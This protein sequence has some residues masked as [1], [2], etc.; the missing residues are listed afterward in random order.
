M[1][2]VDYNSEVGD[3]LALLID[4]LSPFVEGV[5]ATKLP[6]EVSWASLLE[7]KDSIAGR[8]GGIYSPRDLSLLLRALTERIGELGFPFDRELPR[9]GQTY[10][11]ELR[12][13]RNQ[14]AHNQ[15]F[16]PQTAYR[17]V[18]SAEL[19][20][21][22]VGA[23]TQ[24]DALAAL[25]QTVLPV[26]PPVP[27]VPPTDTTI[28]ETDAAPAGPG[29]APQLPR[30]AAPG[31]ATVTAASARITIKSVP[32]LSYA[33]AHCRVPVVDEIIIENLGGET[34]GASIEVD[35]VSGEG[36]LGGPKVLL[37]DLDE[38]KA[39]TLRTI[40]L[41][42]DPARMLRVEE[43]RPGLIRAVLR[44][45]AG[46]QLAETSVDVQIL[47][48]NQWIATPLH[49][50]LELLAAHVQPNA[51]AIAPLLLEASD[52]LKASTGD[53]SLSGYQAESAERVDATVA[54]IYDAMQARDIRYAEPPASWGVVGQKVRTPAEVLENRLGTC[55][56]TT[57]TLA[58]ALEQAGLNSTLWLL[59]GHIFLG[60]W[61]F[62]SS[63]GAIA[64]TDV[65]D[66]VNLVDLGLIGLIETTSLTGGDA[67]LPFAEARRI[68]HTRHLAA[69]LEKFQGVTDIRQAREARI[70][71]LPSRSVGADGEIT[72]TIYQPG[73]G[74]VIAPYYATH[75]AGGAVD[76]AA[77]PP[78]VA[79]WKNALLDLSLRN[80]LINYTDRSGYPLAVPPPAVARMEDAISAGTP[81]TLIPSDSVPTIDRARGIRFGRDLPEDTRELML[82]DKKSAFIEIT[83]ASYTSKLRYLA[84]KA[85]TIVEETGANNLY[86]AFGMLHWRFN[87]RDLR[88]P[89][90]LVPVNMTSASRGTSYRLT[91]DE[92]GASTPNYCLIEKLRVSLGLDIPGLANATEDGSGIDLPAAFYAVREAIALAGLPFRVEETVELSVLQFAKFRLWKDLD[93]NWE[94]LS[95]NSLVSHLINSPLESYAD[96]VV[97]APVVDLDEL[98]GSVPVPADSSQLEAVAEAVGG[99]TFVLEGPPGTGKSQTITNLLARSLAS[100]K[101]VLFVAEKRAALDVVK[102][103]LE[104]VGLGD[105]SLDLHDKGARPAAVRAQIKAALDLRIQP[106]VAALT[107]NREAAVSSRGALA[108]YADRLHEANTAGKSLYE[109]HTD[110]LAADVDITAL[111]IPG[112]L[113]AGSSPEAVAE[114]RDVFRR[115]PEVSDLARAS[116]SHPWAFIVERP[117][118]SLDAAAIQAAGRE[119]DS[120]LVA[121]QAAGFSLESLNRM[122]SA[123]RIEEWRNLSGAP[124]HPIAIIDALHGEAW[125]AY[126]VRLQSQ[127]ASVRAS[128]PE[129]LATVNPT[130][131][132]R[133]L[134]AIHAAALAADEAGFFGRKKKR[135][136]V[137]AEFADDLLIEAASVPLKTL[138]TLTGA[139]AASHADASSVRD[140]ALQL[141][142]PLV[143]A[144]W[145]PFID[146]QAERL[147]NDITWLFWLGNLITAPTSEAGTSVEDLREYYGS[148]PLA[149]GRDQLARLAEVWKTLDT[150]AAIQPER[151]S[152]W[153]GD[154]G[155]V[156]LWWHTRVARTLESTRPVVLE[157]W[158]SLVRHLEP[159]LRSGL[160][161]AHTA[162]LAGSIPAEDAALAFDKGV[163]IASIA[164]RED[165]TALGDFNIAAHNKTIG[166]FTA[167]THAVR[168]E[169][170]R[171]IPAE[172]L[173]LRKFDTNVPSG[174]VG[175]LR[176]QLDRQRGGMSVRA[177]LEN[178]GEL[179]TQVMPCTLMSP[180]SVARFFPAKSNLFD[181]VVF[182]EASQIRV[183][184]AIGAMGRAASV[185]VVGDSKQMP[186]TSFA[187]ASASIEEDGEAAPE[188]VADEES[189]L[190]ECVQAR[191]PS[192]WLS[193]HYRSQDESLIAFSN[194]HYYESRLLSFPAPLAEGA[195]DSVDGHGI[196][197]VRVNGQFERSGRGKTLRTNF[198]EATAIVED[199]RRRFWASPTVSPSVGVITFNAQQRDLV[200][201]MLRDSD[202]ERIAL[203]LDETDGLFVKNLEN[204]QGD[205]RDSILFSIAFSANDKGVVPLNF[206]PLSRAGGERRLNV[207]ITRARRQVVLFTSFD[208]SS[209]RAQDT[210]S[211]GIK[212][213]KAYLEM[214]ER[215]ADVMHDE[216]RRQ[217]TIDRHRDD[218]AAALTA[219]GLSVHTDVGL[220][221]F[222]VDISIA[223]AAD[224]DRPLV[225]VLLDGPNW[226]ARRT[227]ADRDGL[228]VDVLQGIMR[229]PGVERVWLPE[230]LHNR[231]ETLARLG[232]AVVAAAAV[233]TR[234][235]DEPSIASTVGAT[236][237][238]TA[239]ASASGAKTHSAAP[240]ARGGEAPISNRSAGTVRGS[241]TR[242][243]TRSN[244]L[245]V[246][247]SEWAAPRYPG[248]VSVL[249]ALPHTAATAKV[250]AVI[251]SVVAA[252]GP[253]H[254]AR[255]TKLVAGAFGLDRVSQSR[256]AAILRC[257]PADLRLT[258]NEP[259]FWPAQVDPSEWH[260]ARRTPIGEPRQLEHV[261][262]VEIANAMRLMTEA[263]AGMEESELK[264]ES[265]ALFGGRRITDAI[266]VRLDA[267]LAFGLRSGRLER[268][269]SGMVVTGLR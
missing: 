7:R 165:A 254:S 2:K 98:G 70:F 58:A 101:R 185:V 135:R 104:S 81:I 108:R 218:I 235:K 159:L 191:V 194:H 193:W 224:P 239:S 71:P 5:F 74:P 111:I 202:D 100:G 28:A 16:T 103:R 76:A 92:A 171:A 34:R 126:L 133:D 41:V 266:G 250:E 97:G 115:L 75:T 73:A 184:D 244:P 225:A 89:L 119:F 252:E 27:T 241:S 188:V 233:A 216:V 207:A 18:D 170:P 234:V 13:V 267:A 66:I 206:G 134:V 231:E 107:A 261:S 141:P 44:N 268:T 190:T 158:L 232:A 20:L 62:D 152:L 166:R 95:K 69:G 94:T 246:E 163:A 23:D 63:L 262:L 147:T 31:N 227:V 140:A 237:A 61:R 240:S 102:K 47:A 121:A 87:D 258:L 78:R 247:F 21:R 117:G 124:R 176:R 38:Q 53:S 197:L 257:V 203:A 30:P 263:A 12:E 110:L 123:D 228:P 57:V 9:Q 26:K 114:L 143:D 209:L 181:I 64:V 99:R 253:I 4:G 96:P 198:V 80:K 238:A 223:D 201:N 112:A 219:Q 1:D 160:T 242:N 35:V 256:V 17:A 142:M 200:E 162:I 85:K 24:A 60:F 208:P 65:A 217:S 132:A 67:A 214:A 37:V 49:L 116:S 146:Q 43:Q 183:A 243:A 210:S 155:F 59:E 174:Q 248:S 153:A 83:D 113:V 137:L 40:D 169:L 77:V 264:R 226:R 90:V 79:Q 205:E 236:A 36:S 157:R 192:K 15:E 84:N 144:E 187:E 199:I 255:L 11:S 88:S 175:G 45:S 154:V 164:E 229:W 128:K 148:T 230:W 161:D 120:A 136:A 6:P 56:D 125:Q 204:V 269:G 3:A 211:V 50:G 10:A 33:M 91:I 131:L 29:Q 177:L 127:L 139:L 39:T 82:A 172:V 260:V 186:P 149:S 180:E 167:S 245:V 25:K 22:M 68:P 178:Y 212:H 130:V 196:S 55:L 118:T 72:V 86:L 46:D 220:S 42:L 213:L 179:I 251:R 249:D 8:R 105:F 122:G 221:D 168:A 129:W 52:L 151:R 265:L 195:Q 19:L 173:N 51:A 145:N 54:A 14:W 48:F 215:G 32:Y 156:S 222:R 106:D 150:V 109:A 259:F 189:I 138:S 93:E 182:D